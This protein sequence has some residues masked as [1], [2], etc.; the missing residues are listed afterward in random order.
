[1]TATAACMPCLVC[2]G[3]GAGGGGQTYPRVA[4]TSALRL[5]RWCARLPPACLAAWHLAMRRLIAPS[6]LHSRPGGASCT[7]H[8]SGAGVAAAGCWF[9]PL[10][11]FMPAG[12]TPRRFNTARN[13]VFSHTAAVGTH[14]NNKT[15]AQPRFRSMIFSLRNL[16]TNEH[17]HVIKSIEIR[18][19]LQSCR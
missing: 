2:G 18:V 7:G 19:E 14:A 11:A 17:A 10:C 1:M 16:Y 6:G 5:S 8:G 12:K 9:M 13:R 4:R 3:G 15:A